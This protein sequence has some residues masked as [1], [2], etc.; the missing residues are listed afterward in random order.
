M[1]LS[2]DDRLEL[3]YDTVH[4]IVGLERR[5]RH[6]DHYLLP[7][8]EIKHLRRV[9][10]RLWHGLL[11]SYT[12]ESVWILEGPVARSVQGPDS[13]WAAAVTVACDRWTRE[14]CEDD[15][16]F[17]DPFN[18]FL[19]IDGLL[20]AAPGGEARE[21]VYLI[22][23]RAE[24]L[25]YALRRYDDDFRHKLQR[26]DRVV[27]DLLGACYSVMVEDEAYARAYVLSRIARWIYD[28]LKVATVLREINMHF[29][30]SRPMADE[31]P[32]SEVIEWDAWCRDRAGAPED[33]LVLAMRVA[34]RRLHYKHDFRSLLEA[35]RE[36]DPRPSEEVLR[37]EFQKCVEADRQSKE[38][39][40]KRRVEAAESA[41][42]YVIHRR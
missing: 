6:L 39:E 35:S 24:T 20:R 27:S 14:P 21:A 29:K 28:D 10:G 37:E 17:S 8:T 2:D 12:N 36:M 18:V 34:G 42:T 33:R 4:E 31:V 32:L 22:M 30:L 13:P 3:L 19:G 7:R 5:L 41:E 11:R 16:V 9:I 25:V 38:V 1:G 15:D 40:A 26:L 23:E